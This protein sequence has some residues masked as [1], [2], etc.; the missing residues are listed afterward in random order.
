MYELEIRG[1]SLFNVALNDS[2]HVGLVIDMSK[3]E[4]KK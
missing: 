4:F 1:Y 3:C 2:I